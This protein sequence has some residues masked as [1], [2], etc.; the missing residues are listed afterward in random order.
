M[1]AIFIYILL[2]VPY[3]CYAHE[4]KSDTETKNDFLLRPELTPYALTRITT[5][6]PSTQKSMSIWLLDGDKIPDYKAF[7]ASLP[8]QVSLCVNPFDDASVDLIAFARTQGRDIALVINTQTRLD[9]DACSA[10]CFNVTNESIAFFQHFVDTHTIKTIFLPDSADIDTIILTPL[11]DFIKKNKVSV[12][13]PP[14]LFSNLATLLKDNHITYRILDVYV[15]N[16]LAFNDYKQHLTDSM[17]VL[18]ANDIEI[19]LSAS[20]VP[21]K[22]YFQVYLD[23][24]TTK[25]RI[26]K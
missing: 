19:A 4:A 16:S 7:I 11:I 6:A 25:Q 5:T 8:K 10:A 24:L 22:T 14:Q 13:L 15:A 20:S 26:K 9:G 23:A 1:I 2:F 3:F 17:K 12:L 18:E 21:K